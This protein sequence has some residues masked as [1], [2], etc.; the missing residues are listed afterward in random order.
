MRI[1]Y[2]ADFAKIERMAIRE[3]FRKTRTAFQLVRAGFRL[4]QKKGYTRIYGHS[5][6]RLVN[7]WSRFGF[8]VMEG[9]QELCFFRF[10]LCG[11][12]RRSGARSRLRDPRRRSLCHHPAG[13]PLGCSGH[14]GEFR[15]ASGHASVCASVAKSWVSVSSILDFRE[16]S[17]M[18][19]LVLVDLH[20]DFRI[21][22]R[23]IRSGR[24]A[25]MRWRGAAPRFPMPG[26]TAF[27]SLL[28]ATSR[29][30]PP[31][32]R[33]MPIPPGFATSGPSAPK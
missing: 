17:A 31:S 5:Q 15:V 28:C 19:T 8:R 20:D 26:K 24:I 27:P 23:S 11:N 7:F 18:P 13:R 16:R 6:K 30:R 25:G 29:R 22:A 14:I 3:E 33:P 12:P 2:F 32:W 4:C 9:G 10:R 1:R 21:P